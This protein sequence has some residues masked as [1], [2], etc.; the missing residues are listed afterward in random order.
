MRSHLPRLHWLEPLVMVLL[1]LPLAL[2]PIL[3][4]VYTSRQV[5]AQTDCTLR[6]DTA[7][8]I[9]WAQ[10]SVKGFNGWVNP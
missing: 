6:L 10:D 1:M 2:I 7:V 8:P 4:A 5:S 3:F 9:V